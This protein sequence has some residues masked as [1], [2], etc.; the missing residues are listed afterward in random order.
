MLDLVA[1]DGAVFGL[2]FFA[3]CIDKRNQP[4]FDVFPE[5]VAQLRIGVPH[6]GEVAAEE[7]SQGH[8]AAGERPADRAPPSDPP[9]KSRCRFHGVIGL[10][11][12]DL[13]NRKQGALGA[14][15]VLPLVLKPL[16]LDRLQYLLPH[17][18]PPP[19]ELCGTIADP[20]SEFAPLRNTSIDSPEAV[21]PFGSPE[22]RET[23]IR[24]QGEMPSPPAGAAQ[25]G[26][27]F[28]IR[29]DRTPRQTFPISVGSGS[30]TSCTR[31]FAPQFFVDRQCGLAPYFPREIGRPYR[32]SCHERISR[33]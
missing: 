21:C 15:P 30:R 4:Q 25:G 31:S 14:I 9:G 8:H 33:Y 11:T 29:I 22:Y 2:K 24:C 13:L 27:A 17:V 32:S 23:A 20:V 6:R 26:D 28:S 12:E 3:E 16:L 10:E 7:E 5:F 1:E 18:E 19:V